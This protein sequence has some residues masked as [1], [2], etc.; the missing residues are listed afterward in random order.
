MEFPS[1]QKCQGISCFEHGNEIVL[2]ELIKPLL[3]IVY[4]SSQYSE[5]SLVYRAVKMS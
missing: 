5:V 4:L 1:S 2:R 3:L